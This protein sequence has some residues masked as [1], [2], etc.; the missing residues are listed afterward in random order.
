MNELA[1]ANFNSSQ[2]ARN[3]LAISWFLGFFNHSYLNKKSF[4]KEK[5]Y[6]TTFDRKR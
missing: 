6:V 1:K 3:S 5:N 4:F 2:E